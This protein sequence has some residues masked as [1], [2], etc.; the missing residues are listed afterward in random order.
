MFKDHIKTF[1]E[2]SVQVFFSFFCRDLASL[3]SICQLFYMLEILAPP[4]IS[5]KYFLLVFQLCFDFVYGAFC[6]AK[7]FNFYVV[8]FYIVKSI[9]HSFLYCI[10]L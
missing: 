1:F 2:L 9:N 6:H 3:P 8:Y 4:D 10:G 7:D 5:C